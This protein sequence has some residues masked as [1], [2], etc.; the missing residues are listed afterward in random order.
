VRDLSASFVIGEQLTATLDGVE[1]VATGL[2]VTDATRTF[3]TTV[4]VDAATSPR[5]L[6]LG[7]AELSTGRDMTSG[8]KRPI[9]L[10][11]SRPL[12]EQ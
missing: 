4:Y 11:S 1:V 10:G 7:D 2:D 12:V 3:Y 5:T 9:V 6:Y 8:A